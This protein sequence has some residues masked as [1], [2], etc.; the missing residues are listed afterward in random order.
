[1]PLYANAVMT[2]TDCL[3]L[4]EHIPVMPSFSLHFPETMPSGDNQSDWLFKLNLFGLDNTLLSESSM[5]ISYPP[6][7]SPGPIIY[8][9][10]CSAAQ[11]LFQSS[12]DSAAHH[13]R[14]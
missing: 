9:P 12:W 3:G 8:Y 14:V 7:Q 13:S 2:N 5:V 1:M 11:I 4:F 10:Q 6:Y